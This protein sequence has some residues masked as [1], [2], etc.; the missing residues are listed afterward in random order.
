MALK[1]N[2]SQYLY[3][4]SIQLQ[5]RI[6]KADSVHKVFAFYSGGAEFESRLGPLLIPFVQTN[7]EMENTL[8]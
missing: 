2:P 4:L 1:W 6:E 3:K 7:A 5:L 8:T